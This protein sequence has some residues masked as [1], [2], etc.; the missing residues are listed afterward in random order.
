M[1][2]GRVLV[3]N[4][5][6]QAINICNTKRA[7]SLL[8]QNRARVVVAEGEI[9]NT[10]DFE[11]W[12]KL[13]SDGSDGEV[14][15][16]VSFVMKVPSIILLLFYDQLPVKE[17]KFSRKNVF[18]RDKN[19]CQYCGRRFETKKLNIDHVVPKA[20]GGLTVWE[21]V[22]CCCSACNRR[23]SNRRLEEVGM[24]LVRKPEKPRWHPLITINSYQPQHP[25]WSHFLRITYGK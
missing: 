15:K 9:F 3:L 13:S 24:H 11:N 23:K 20:A 2:E 21:N 6:W 10:F 8:Y 22:V 25:S 7:I 14:I 16:T 5:L 12:K 17:I 4:R 19:R 18:E 1:L